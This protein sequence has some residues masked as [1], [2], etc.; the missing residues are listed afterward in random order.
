MLC[1]TC[2]ENGAAA[3]ATSPS[4]S[5]PEQGS[6]HPAALLLRVWH[7]DEELRCRLMMVND[8]SSPASV[9]TA[10]QGIDA[11]CDAVRRWLLQV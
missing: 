5:G 8:S 1:R 9:S 10:A 2:R 7:Q 11:I 4:R 6:D 3:A